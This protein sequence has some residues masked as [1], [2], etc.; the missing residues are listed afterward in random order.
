MSEVQD[1]GRSLDQDKKSQGGM[2]YTPPNF[3]HRM[4][5]PLFYNDL[6]ARC[7]EIIKEGNK[8]KVLNFIDEIVDLSFFDPSAG[9]GNIL[10]EIYKS[11]RLLEN[12]C[13]EYLRITNAL[14]DDYYSRIRVDNFYGIEID[15]DAYNLSR[16]VFKK[17]V[18][19]C[20]AEA[21]LSPSDFSNYDFPSLHIGDAVTTD[22]KTI[23]TP[24]KLSFI[25]GNPPYLGSTFQN[26]TQKAQL[27]YAFKNVKGA[28][29]LDYSSIWIL[30]AF[31]FCNR[32]PCKCA[33]ILPY[34]LF[35]GNSIELLWSRACLVNG[36][37]RKVIFAYKPF[38]WVS[39]GFDAGVYVTAIGFDCRV[40]PQK[41]ALYFVDDTPKEVDNINFYLLPAPDVVIAKRETSLFERIFRGGCNRKPQI[42]HRLMFLR[43]GAISS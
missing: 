39:D 33:F 29:V 4:I 17:T 15:E 10:I 20:D 21:N 26:A 24:D 19:E 38:K 3:I 40:R 37:K 7:A 36:L 32:T 18:L 6:K 25:V 11:L 2:F 12:D 1:F 34:C 30:K 35:L 27:K 5:D 41:K 9:A 43:G 42:L 22:W 23:I 8:D 31:T 14:P 13:I 28:G 16:S